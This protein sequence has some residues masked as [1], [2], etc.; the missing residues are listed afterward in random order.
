VALI[1]RLLAS[2]HYGERWGQRWLDVVRYADTG[3]YANDLERSNAWRYRDYVIRSFNEDKPYDQFVLEQ[4]AGDDWK[5]D[6]PEMAIAVGMLRMGPWTTAMVKQDVARQIF[7]DDLVHSVGQVYLGTAMRC[8]KCHD[9]KSDPI[10]T[11]DYYGMYATFAGTQPVEAPVEFLEEENLSGFDSNRVIVEELLAFAKDELAIVK[12]R[13]EAAA[14]KWYEERDLPYKNPTERHGDPEDQKPPVNVAEVGVPKA[15]FQDVNLWTRRLER[16]EPL[17]QTVY[18]A[19][20][21]Y[22]EPGKLRKPE[23][24]DPDAADWWA[25]NIRILLDGSLEAPGPEV[26]P[27]ALSAVGIPLEESVVDGRQVIAPRRVHFAQ[28]VVHPENGIATRTIVNRLWQ[29]HFGHGLAGNPNN[30]GVKGKRPTHPELLDWLS[31]RFLEDGR[32]MK[33]MHRLLMTSKAYQMAAEHPNQKTLERTD[34]N[35]ESY[36]W[37]APRHLSAEEIRDGMLFITGELNTEMGGL[38]VMPEINLEVA[39]QPRMLELSLA[40]AYQP[41]RLPKDRNRRSIYA[42][43]LRN[44]PDPFMEVLHLPNSNES[45]EKRVESAVT[46]QS[47]TLLNSDYASN[48]TFAFAKR[49]AREAEGMEERIQ[50][51]FRLTLLRN[52]TQQE[53]RRMVDYLVRKTDHHRKVQPQEVVYPT[54]VKRTLVEELSGEPISYVEKLAAFENYTPDV[55]AADLTAE[56]RALADLCRLLF[57]SNEFAYVY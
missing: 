57:N 48:R 38:P 39:L 24:E 46:P 37:F 26:K 31:R 35:N 55:S 47:F 42:Y 43:K 1:D 5:P 30:L 45:C 53:S 4:L 44:Q 36:S 34:P 25:P 10:P 9:H 21:F 7:L 27:G 40:P 14:R 16:F 22:Y 28:W 2:P 23:N 32:S 19:P 6:D 56:E 3:G 41:S 20:D 13:R 8:C 50:R 18:T 49:L 11:R 29:G 12:E 52:P 51:A 54:S 15:R 33:R 17:A